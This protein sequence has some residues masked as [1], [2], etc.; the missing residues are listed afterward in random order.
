MT[1]TRE[2]MRTWLGRPFVQRLILLVLAA[3]LALCVGCGLLLSQQPVLASTLAMSQARGSGQGII[4][5]SATAEA[6]A[7]LP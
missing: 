6:Q 1:F 5:L 3:L 4:G 7:T 2:K